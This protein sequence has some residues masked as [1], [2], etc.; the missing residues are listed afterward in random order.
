MSQY[1]FDELLQKYLAGTC[2]PVEEKLILDWY[3]TMI[4]QNAVPVDA[5]EKEA[6]RQRVWQKLAGSTVG[7][8]K[9]RLRT[10]SY[11]FAAGVALL[12]LV[13]LW[14][15]D[16]LTDRKAPLATRV[17]AEGSIEI[18]NSSRSPQV[19]TLEDGTVITLKPAGTLSYPSH[20]GQQNRTVYLKGDAFFRVKKDPAKP[21]IV[22]T[23]DLITE[24]LG[25]SFTIKSH[26]GAKDIEVSVLTGRVSVYRAADRAIRNRQEVILKPNEQITYTTHSNQLIPRLVEQPVEV[27]P[28]SQPISLVFDATPLPDV[29]ARLQMVYGIDIFLESD[30]LN[31]CMLNA[32]LSDLTLFSQLELICKS[33][34]AAYEV[35]GTSIFIKSQ[36]N[37]CP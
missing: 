2:D 30:A 33:M 12:L 15:K 5:R 29:L 22:H 4:T 16:D 9:H 23:G 36:G 3:Q 1:D 31:T 14:R 28:R 32:D 27:T 17:P 8:P 25:T 34:D 10:A 35:R 24:V 26:E 6:I 37:G 18:R 7:P 20:F 19:I 13:V 21:F 11:A